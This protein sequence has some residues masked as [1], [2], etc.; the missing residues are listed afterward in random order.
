M[1][2]LRKLAVAT[3][4]AA[5]LLGG[6]AQAASVTFDSINDQYSFLYTGSYDGASLNATVTYR[7]LGWSGNT[8]RFGVTATNNSSGPGTNR[9]VSFGVGV[10]NPDLTG[11]GTYWWQ[12]W[13]ASIDATSPQFGKIDLCVWDGNNCAGGGSQGVYE[14]NTESF[15]LFLYFNSSV[16]TTRPITFASPFTSK[17]QSVGTN[18]RSYEFGGCLVGS[19]QPCDTTTTKVPEPATLGLLGM[20]LLGVGAARFRRRKA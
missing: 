3:A 19:E 8:A 11:A 12:G 9:L 20:G 6:T 15:D 5:A 16:G 17:W 18:G 4:A 7:L 10:V 13:G 1:L 2:T 14:N